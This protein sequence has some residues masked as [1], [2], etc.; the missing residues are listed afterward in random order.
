[1]PNKDW[2]QRRLR[3]PFFLKAHRENF[4]SRA[5][6]KLQEILEKYRLIKTGYSVLDL[7]AA[8]GS[9]TQVALEA[10]GVTPTRQDSSAAPPGKERGRGLVIGI[11]LLEI[12]ELPGAHLLKGDI[13][14]KAMQAAIVNLAPRGFHCILSDMAPNTTGIHHADT[15][16]SVDLIHLALD[17][18][19]TWLRPGGSFVAKLFEGAEYKELHTRAGRLFEFVKSFKPKASLSK[20]R[21]I[22]LVC[23]NYRSE[24]KK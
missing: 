4:R 18:C 20:S 24:D 15:S 3:D 14:D 7:G 8:P 6:Y 21:E 22:Y 11:D 19:P 12:E 17:M 9:W 10:T 5:A 1:M 16:N 2:Y 23:Q 13:R